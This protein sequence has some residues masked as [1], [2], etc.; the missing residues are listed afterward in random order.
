MVMEN[1]R[2]N[3][4][5]SNSQLLELYNQ[6]YVYALYI[7]IYIYIYIYVYTRFRGQLFY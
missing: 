1:I 2:S 4:L 7:Y 6:V 3:E 5:N